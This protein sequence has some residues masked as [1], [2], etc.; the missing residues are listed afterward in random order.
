MK[1]NYTTTATTDNG[2]TITV[3]HVTGRQAEHY[4]AAVLGWESANGIICHVSITDHA[5]GE[6]V[7]LEH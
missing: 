4:A 3:H 7:E 6:I 5:T 1:H 2:T